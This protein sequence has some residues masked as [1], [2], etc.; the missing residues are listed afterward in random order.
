MFSVALPFR[1]TFDQLADKVLD[2]CLDPEAVKTFAIN[3]GSSETARM[4]RELLV[5]DSTAASL[6][7]NP[8]TEP[9]TYL[10][11]S[12]RFDGHSAPAR[13]RPRTPALPTTGVR[14]AGKSRGFMLIIL[15]LP[16]FYCTSGAF[17]RESCTAKFFEYAGPSNTSAV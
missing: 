3:G 6:V 9:Q 17:P 13:S 8:A 5:G 1:Q 2:A 11:S 10:D 16:D 14:F 7:L 12:D 4:I 15:S